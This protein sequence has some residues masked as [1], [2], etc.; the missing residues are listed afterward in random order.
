MRVEA[1][2][3]MTGVGNRDHVADVLFLSLGTVVLGGRGL[4]TAEAG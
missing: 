1:R 3:G 2:R 4:T